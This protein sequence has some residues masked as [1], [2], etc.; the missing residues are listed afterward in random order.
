M[1]STEAGVSTETLSGTVAWRMDPELQGVRV[2]DGRTMPLIWHY[3]RE[4]MPQVHKLRGWAGSTAALLHFSPAGYDSKCTRWARERAAQVLKNPREALSKVLDMRVGSYSAVEFWRDSG[5]K[6]EQQAGSLGVFKSVNKCL[7]EVLRNP[8]CAS[9][10][11]MHSSSSGE[12]RCCAAAERQGGSEWSTYKADGWTTIRAYRPPEAIATWKMGTFL[13]TV[14]DGGNLDMFFEDDASGRQRYKL[15]RGDGDWYTISINGGTNPGAKL[16]S[17]SP[18]GKKVRLVPKD[19]GSGRE[20]WVI[21]NKGAWYN[22]RVLGGVNPGVALFS[23]APCGCRS[24]VEA[25]DDGS[26]R[27]RWVLDVPGR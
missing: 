20:R 18:D 27:Q 2:T 6:A 4:N 25:K 10:L 22:I 7:P 23:R 3:I 1:L 15:K 5:C 26:G 21:E 16:L 13:S 9:G 14:N 12:C 19:T 11:F 24:E 8:G 17:S